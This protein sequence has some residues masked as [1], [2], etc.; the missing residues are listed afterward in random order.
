MLTYRKDIDG[1]R[2][3]AVLSVILF[4]YNIPG[5]E[6]G[7][8]GVDIFFVISGFLIGSIILSDLGRSRFSFTAFYERRVRRILPAL[9]T[10]VLACF[11]F[12][13]YFLNS[14]FLENLAQTAT[15]SVLFIS[16]IYFYDTTG[17][18]FAEVTGPNILLHTWSLS[19]EEQFYILYP[20]LIYL[21]YKYARKYI[22]HF[23]LV[24][25][26]I[27]LGGSI[28]LTN[29]NEVFS[30][31][32]P[33]TRSWEFL[34][35]VL[36][37][38]VNIP[39]SNKILKE[40]FSLLG[41]AF[42]IAGLVALN[43]H[44]VFPGYSALLPVA[45]TA[46]LIKY[47][48]HSFLLNRILCFRPL[49]FIGKIS[50][51]LYLWHWPVLIFSEYFIYD[52]LSLVN[53]IY[54]LLLTFLLSILSWRYVERPFRRKNRTKGNSK[55]A[56]LAAGISGAFLVCFF[57]AIKINKGFPDFENKMFVEI[58]NDSNPARYLAYSKQ[59]IELD[60]LATLPKIGDHHAAPSFLL[61]GDSH[62]GSQIPGFEAACLEKNK[63]GFVAI[64]IGDP[65]VLTGR[66]QP[67]NP[68][69]VNIN[70]AIIRFLIFHPEIKKIFLSAR[71][72][73]YPKLFLNNEGIKESAFSK[74][75][76]NLL[77]NNVSFEKEIVRVVDTLIRMDREVI[78]L[79]PTPELKSIPR[80]YVFY[81][82]L[83]NKNINSLTPT[84]KDFLHENK[85]IFDL[86]KELDNHPN[87]QL[88]SV[89]DVLFNK[90]TIL[91][92]NNDHL[93]FIDKDHLS[94]RGA[95]KLK[96]SILNKL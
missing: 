23:I 6:G 26:I 53:I 4:H 44:S 41:A 13:F 71:W 17:G 30:F 28:I 24:I 64:T 93:V 94:T 70:S 66:M 75:T 48:D 58:K 31:Y 49:V 65:P 72:S 22:I 87:I 90:G 46:L 37:A 84:K 32:L 25:A 62:A 21:L 57:F 92:D 59:A 68:N 8:T 45:G 77:E 16:N 52:T 63:S 96:D 88:L 74:T 33:F 91:L 47:A 80:K 11:L 5:L 89:H 50:Y 18:Y 54:L 79:T 78:L 27:S 55:K 19:L 2:G 86:F 29:D 69:I 42:I 3:I 83:F 36:L 12:S 10:V 35:G 81:A 61:W 20:P 60:S 40:V 56:F 7:F 15:T 95:I 67:Y 82:K 9:Y 73:A 1:L 38:G 14:T 51:S 76:G 43:A 34:A 85:R 39:N